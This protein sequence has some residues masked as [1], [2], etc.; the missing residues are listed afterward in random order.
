MTILVTGARGNIGSHLVAQLAA[1]GHSVR[2]SAR[3]VSTLR[4]PAGAEAVELD[5]TS[6]DNAAEALR[7][8]DAIFLYP[9]RGPAPDEFLKAAREAGVRYVVLLSSPDVYEGADDNPIRLAHVRVE[10]SLASSGLRFTV[11]Y[12]GWLA[13]DAG[14]DWGEQ[15]RAEGRVAIAYPEAQFTP[16]HIADVAEVAAELLTRDAYP[17]RALALTGPESLRQSEIVAILSEVL[18][19]PIP[20]DTLTRQQALDRRAPWMPERVLDVLLHSTAAAVGVPAPINNTVERFTGHPARTFREW[21]QENR[22]TF[23]PN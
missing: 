10:K 1:A 13:T 2:G 20:L 4:L 8:V 23:E 16:I 21:A 17:G 12:P 7:D 14:R 3:D 18:G 22:A 6:P 11:L 15:I 19:R 5:I 9:T